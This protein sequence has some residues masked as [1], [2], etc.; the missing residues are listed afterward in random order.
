MKANPDKYHLLLSG[1]DASKITIRNKTISGSKCQKLL[2]IKVD[3]N[4][5]LQNL[6]VKKQA[7]KLMLF[8][9]LRHQ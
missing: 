1:T 5:N 2:G 8:L 7:R 4:L 9:D 6:C 3:N